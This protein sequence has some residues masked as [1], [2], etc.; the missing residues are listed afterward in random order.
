VSPPIAA[1]TEVVVPPGGVARFDINL[2]APPSSVLGTT[3]PSFVATGSVLSTDHG[4]VPIP[5]L[6]SMH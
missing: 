2:R 3:S 4:E 5:P 1:Q 6:P